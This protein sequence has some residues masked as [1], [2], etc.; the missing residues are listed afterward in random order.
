MSNPPYR[1]VQWATGAMGK[2]CLRAVLDHPDMQLAGLWVSSAAKAGQDAGDI[3]HRPRTGILATRSVEDILA[4]QADVVIHA[5]LLQP[6]YGAHDENIARLLESGKNVLSINGYSHPGRWNPARRER[7][8]AAC[9]RGGTSLMGAGLNPG[10]IGEK[11]AVTATSICSEVRAIEITETVDCSAMRNPDY[12]FGVLGFNAD[13]ASIDPNN[14]DWGPASALNGMYADVLQAMAERLGWP[15]EEVRSEHELRASDERRVVSA[16]T[17]ER[18][19]V[20]SLVWRWRGHGGGSSSAQPLLGMTII[21]TME[22]LLPHTPLWTVA[23]DGSPGVRL[24]VD[25][26]RPRDSRFRT[27]AEQLGVAGAVLNAI[28]VLCAAP[29]GVVTMPLAT[30]WRQRSS[31]S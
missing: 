12:V 26:E 17:I 13:P 6:P 9:L 31:S 8:E 20:G 22:P 14:P 23:I 10:Y 2:T 16:G 30:P 24:H 27:S 28:P 25:L 29:P 19:K 18:G 11:I 21:W 4:I 7:L 1:V 3:A 5:G 15:L